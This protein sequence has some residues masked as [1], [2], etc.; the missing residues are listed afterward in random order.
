VS[1]SLGQSNTGFGIIPN[2]CGCTT[3]QAGEG[4]PSPSSSSGSSVDDGHDSG[5]DN[6]HDRSIDDGNERPN[7]VEREVASTASRAVGDE[8]DV[9]EEGAAL[10]SPSR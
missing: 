10:R 2:P 6:G 4:P 8:E 7:D 9:E 5:V 1:A 3:C